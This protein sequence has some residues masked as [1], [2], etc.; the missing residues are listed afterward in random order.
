MLVM[1]NRL[2]TSEMNCNFCRS[3]K[4]NVLVIRKSKAL[5]SSPKLRLGFTSASGSPA[6]QGTGPPTAPVHGGNAFH[7]W[8]AAFSEAPSGTSRPRAFRRMLGKRAVRAGT[9]ESMGTL[10]AHVQ[11]GET[12]SCHG[13]SKTPKNTKRCRSSVG[14]Y[15]FSSRRLLV[16]KIRLT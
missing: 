2:N 7:C 3:V 1:L 16:W 10:E 6:W 11:M 5:K 15:P 12:L 13:A 8:I 9:K 14:A 4:L